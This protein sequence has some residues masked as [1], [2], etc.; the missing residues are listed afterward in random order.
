MSNT[1]VRVISHYD[2][3]TQQTAMY[4]VL[5]HLLYSLPIQQLLVLLYTLVYDLYDLPGTI[6]SAVVGPTPVVA[7][8]W[9]CL[10]LLSGDLV[11]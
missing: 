3:N 2:V 1:V 8:T 4:S 9:Y 11:W 5:P 6:F 7:C 10:L